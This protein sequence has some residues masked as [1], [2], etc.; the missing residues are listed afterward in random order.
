[1]RRADVCASRSFAEK[2]T[3]RLRGATVSGRDRLAGASA[4]TLDARRE[5]HA[6]DWGVKADHPRFDAS[7]FPAP[8]L[9]FSVM[10]SNGRALEATQLRPERGQGGQD[11]QHGHG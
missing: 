11:G 4:H 5:E 8:T 3:S 9:T 2:A 6:R 1:M 10:L 7:D